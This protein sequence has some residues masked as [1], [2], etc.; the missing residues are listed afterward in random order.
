M[1]VFQM[2]R[3]I[4]AAERGRASLVYNNK[5]IIYKLIYNGWEPEEVSTYIGYCTDNYK[6]NLKPIGSAG[7]WFPGMLLHSFAVE[8]SVVCS[9]I[10]IHILI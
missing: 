10:A 9:L 4:F 6:R 7:I 2:S 1:N 8:V 5:L 3:V